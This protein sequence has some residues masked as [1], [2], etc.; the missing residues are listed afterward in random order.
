MEYP[1]RWVVIQINDQKHVLAGYMGGYLGSD[2][3]RRS[4][5]IKSFEKAEDVIIATTSSGNKY[6]LNMGREGF[7]NLT[8]TI[9]TQMEDASKENN[10]NLAIV[11]SENLV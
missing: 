11:K 6:S 2:S 9:Y 4:S 5:P 7:T 10:I 1:D 8:S 3:Y